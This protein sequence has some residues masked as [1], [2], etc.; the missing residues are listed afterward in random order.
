MRLH[1][2][3]VSGFS[4]PECLQKFKKPNFSWRSPL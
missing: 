1:V 2:N 4:L 3:N